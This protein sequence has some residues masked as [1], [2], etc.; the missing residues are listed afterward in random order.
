[1]ARVLAS[2]GAA[3][4]LKVGLIQVGGS[5]PNVALMRLAT[6]HRRI[7]DEVILDAKP[8][9][10]CD[11]VYVSTLFT[12]QR[13][14]VIELAAH[15]SPH[16][17]VEIGGSGWD[18]AKRLPAE[19]DAMPNE[20][21][22]YGISYGVGY[23]SRGCIRHCAFCPVPRAEGHVREDQPIAALLNPLSNRLI[24]LDNNF[25][26]SDW[27]PKIEEIRN[28][29]LVVD[30]PQGIDIRLVDRE[31]ASVLGDLR[32]HG[33]LSGDRFT[34]PGTLHFA[35]DLPSN[36]ARPDTVTGGIRLL[37]DA[38]FRPRDLRCYVL[39]G[40]P[41][42]D[43]AEEVARLTTLHALGIE[44]YVMVYRDFGERDRRDVRRMDLQHW[45][46]GHVWRSVEWP[47]YRRRSRKGAVFA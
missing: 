16:A 3:L 1:M 17:D 37:F 43:L 20:Y 41:G 30:W 29:G 36:D 13:S 26:A 33:Q 38:G 14:K 18:L 10:A 2:V 31:Q 12:W 9:D 6:W 27:R 39:I 25:F 35:W 34:R 42:Y 46:N 44:P 24:L 19:V 21:S 22:L 7:G 11:R 28:R 32:T 8:T 15:F 47:E 4:M 5:L 40:Y 45:N 23:S